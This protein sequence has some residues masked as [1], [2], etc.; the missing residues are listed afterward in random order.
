MS[1][2]GETGTDTTVTTETGTNPVATE[3]VTFKDVEKHRHH[4]PKVEAPR[5]DNVYEFDGQ[6]TELGASWIVLTIPKDA[7][8]LQVLA[9]KTKKNQIVKVRLEVP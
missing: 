8:Q 7:Q 3:T 9:H 6:I 5:P 4:K 1:E 2:E